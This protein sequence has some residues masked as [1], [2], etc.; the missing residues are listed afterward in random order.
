MSVSQH[1]QVFDIESQDREFQCS[2]GTVVSALQFHRWHQVSDITD[3]EQ[4]TRVCLKQDG[5]IDA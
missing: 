1:D 3:Y 4:I 5:R 2:T